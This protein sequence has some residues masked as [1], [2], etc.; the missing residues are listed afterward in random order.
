[1]KVIS[2]YYEGTDVVK[3]KRLEYLDGYWAEFT[4]NDNGKIL[5][6][7]DSDDYYRI[8]GK[9]ATKEEFEAF[10]NPRPLAGKKVT[11]DGVEY[12]LK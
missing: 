3:F 11:I 6:V 9:R 1:M 8:K 10:T 5:T 2:E 12:E 4:F 7:K